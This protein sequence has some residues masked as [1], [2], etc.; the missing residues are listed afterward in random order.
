MAT[1][2]D[3][4]EGLYALETPIGRAVVRTD[5]NTLQQNGHQPADP[6]GFAADYDEPGAFEQAYDQTPAGDDTAG[7]NAAYAAEQANPRPA[8]AGQGPQDPGALSQAFGGAEA[9]TVRTPPPR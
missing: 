2:H 7:F 9:G 5:E 6:E 4:G 1:Y 3:L 8:G